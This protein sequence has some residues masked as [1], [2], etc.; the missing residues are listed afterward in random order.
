MSSFANGQVNASDAKQVGAFNSH[1]STQPYVNGYTP[2]KEDLTAFKAF[3]GTAPAEGKFPHAARWYKHIASFQPNETAAW[4]GQGSSGRTAA[5]G[6]SAVAGGSGSGGG[7]GDDDF[8]LFGED[9]DEDEEK[10]RVTEERLKA[11]AEKKAKKPGVIAKSSVMLDVKPWEDETDL[12]E[13]EKLVRSIEMDGLVWGASK[14]V[15]L[16]YGI[17]K[18]QILCTIVDEKVSVDSDLVERIQDDFADHVQSV[19]IAAFNKI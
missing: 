14:L 8:D 4:P 18:L 11:Y 5:N 13:M 1:L 15:P 10:K 9:S 6:E 7:G 17:Q 19:D 3:G 2:A 16:A 12:K